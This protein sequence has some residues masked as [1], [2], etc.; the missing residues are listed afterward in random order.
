MAKARQTSAIFGAAT[1]A[2]LTAATVFSP[3]ASLA[4]GTT[5]AAQPLTPSWTEETRELHAASM[6]TRDYAENNNGVG[7]LIHVAESSFPN[8]HFQ[9]P[10]QFGQA[11]VGAFKAHYGTDSKYFLR[12]NLDARAT[13]ITYH[14]GEFIHGAGEG[15]EVKNVQEAL[16]AMP[17]VAGLLKI[18]WEDKLAVSLQNGE[19]SPTP[20]G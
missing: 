12:N 10:D 14:V 16:D 2:F 20:E 11:V 5:S 17:E 13:G 4:D 8:D 9:T 3:S 1:G 18:I 6:S 19:P 15:K 7:I